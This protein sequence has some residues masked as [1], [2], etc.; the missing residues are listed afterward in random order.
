MESSQPR[1]SQAYIQSRRPVLAPQPA[2]RIARRATRCRPKRAA[3]KALQ[4]VRSSSLGSYRRPVDH[5]RQSRMMP[6]RDR[7]YDRQPQLVATPED[8]QDDEMVYH[9]EEPSYDEEFGD[10]QEPQEPQDDDR[11]V[12]E[13]L[14]NQQSK[15]TLTLINKIRTEFLENMKQM[16]TESSESM[17]QTRKE[18]LEALKQIRT[19]Y[20]LVLT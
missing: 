13:A 7:M 14:I 9:D 11:Y 16:R 4:D 10:P 6:V 1:P 3:R 18:F 2:Q 20:V 17:K 15:A 12:L 19:E 8:E 5:I